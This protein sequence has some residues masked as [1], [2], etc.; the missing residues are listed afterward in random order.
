MAEEKTVTTTAAETGEKPEAA[1]GTVQEKPEAA[2]RTYNQ[3]YVDDLIER[4][5]AAQEA[6]VAEA[7]KVAGMDKDAK[8]KYEQEQAEEKMAKREA[9]IARRELKADAREVLAEKQI[10]TEF[11]DM[12]LGSDLKETKANA[13]AFKTK[14]DAAVQAQVEKRLA[15]KTPQGGNGRLQ[16]GT[17]MKSEIEKYMA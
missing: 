7:L 12:L 10:P 1:E 8:E 16:S 2:A 13:D 3:A 4:Q 9:D 17:S 5:K 11:L 6:A 15:G 14:F